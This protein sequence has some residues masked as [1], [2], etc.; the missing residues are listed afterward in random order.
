MSESENSDGIISEKELIE[1]VDLFAQFEG[2]PD[3]F[4]KACKEAK[5]EFQARISTIYFDRIESNPSFKE[6]RSSQFHSVIR[7]TCR[8]RLNAGG[9]RYLCP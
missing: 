1:L 3:P 2:A 4:S 9:S 5:K 6:V 8:G 7:N